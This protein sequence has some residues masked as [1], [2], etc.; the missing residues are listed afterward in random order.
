MSC[1]IYIYFKIN[2]WASAFG[3]TRPAIGFIGPI[4]WA[5]YL[6]KNEGTRPAFLLRKFEI[7]PIF[8]YVFE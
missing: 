3:L 1:W 2:H 6:L 8:Q 5:N 7:A 4:N